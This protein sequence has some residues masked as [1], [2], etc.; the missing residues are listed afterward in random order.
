M[1]GRKIIWLNLSHTAI[2]KSQDKNKTNKQKLFS[3]FQ[4]CLSLFFFFGLCN[5][6]F[7]YI[8]TGI[9]YLRE[10]IYEDLRRINDF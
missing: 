10:L 7:A 5:I 1:R 9:G 6:F 8:E 4:M 3:A 2:I